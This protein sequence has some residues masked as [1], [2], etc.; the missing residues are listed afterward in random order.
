MLAAIDGLYE[1]GTRTPILI[2]DDVLDEGLA[3]CSCDTCPESLCIAIV[4]KT[5]RSDG[6]AE[7]VNELKWC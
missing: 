1:P 4:A 6:N 3:V 2:L 7:L 5:G